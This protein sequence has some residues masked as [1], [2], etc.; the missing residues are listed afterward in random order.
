MGG[1]GDTCS[2]QTRKRIQIFKD[3]IVQ[4]SPAVLLGVL[5]QHLST[6]VCYSAKPNP[7]IRHYKVVYSLYKAAVEKPRFLKKFLGYLGF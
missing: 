6:I 5:Y 1:T 7:L 4:Y 3:T 2:S